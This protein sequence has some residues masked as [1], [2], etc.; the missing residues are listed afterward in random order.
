MAR[1]L[2]VD[3]DAALR[4]LLIHALESAGHEVF[5][6]ENGERAEDQLRV[7][8][9]DL[10]VTDLVM[11]FR[12]G[13]ETIQLVKRLNPDIKIIAMSGGGVFLN[14]NYLV[15]A[16]AFG[17]RRA[18]GKPFRLRLFLDTVQEVLNEEPGGCA[19]AGHDGAR[20]VN[21]RG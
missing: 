5:S 12:D 2:V 19:E 3:D 20:I 9:V 13:L 21:G 8:N 17:A 18:L 4:K 10:V 1:V 7:H 15:A 11:P 6:A 14:D 16:L